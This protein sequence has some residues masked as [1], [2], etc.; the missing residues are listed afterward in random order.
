MMSIT[1]KHIENELR[2][3]IEGVTEEMETLQSELSEYEDALWDLQ[4]PERANGDLE[5]WLKDNYPDDELPE[6]E[7]PINDPSL[8]ARSLLDLIEAQS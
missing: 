1:R 2:T 6:Y 3:L 5:A 7:Q 8:Y 4:H